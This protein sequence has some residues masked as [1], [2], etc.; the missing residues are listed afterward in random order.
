M[1]S[2]ASIRSQL[3]AYEPATNVQIGIKSA[4]AMFVNAEPQLENDECIS[5]IREDLPPNVLY[6]PDAL[7]GPATLH[8][9]LRHYLQLK[10]AVYT[11]H[12]ENNRIIFGL[13]SM[14]YN[15]ESDC[16]VALNYLR[17][18]RTSSN[19]SSI[20]Q[21]SLEDGV[22]NALSI[23][24][25][26]AGRIAHNMATRFKLA[27]DKFSG[28]LDENLTEYLN[29]YMDASNDYGLTLQQ[30]F[31]YLHHLFDGEAKRFFR[32]NVMESCN[33]FSEACSL[34]QQEFNSLTRQS[35]VRK[36][37][38]KL[39]IGEV[40]NRKKC[41]VAEALEELREL[42]TKLAPQ[43][44]KTHRSDEAKVEYLYQAVV[45]ASWAKASLSAS[46][47]SNPP[48]TFQKLY[49]SLD[50]AWLQEQEEIEA[51]QRDKGGRNNIESISQGTLPGIFYQGQGIY[52]KPRQV[53]SKSSAPG[54]RYSHSPGSEAAIGKNGMD[55]YGRARLCNNCKSPDHF[56][57]ACDK[58]KNLVNNVAKMIQNKKPAEIR[59]ILYEVCMQ[60]ENA[61]WNDDDDPMNIFFSE[62]REMNDNQEIF[63][64]TDEIHYKSGNDS[65][66]PKPE[67]F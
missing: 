21:S 45:G 3:A 41:S 11:Q 43:G 65:E 60:A 6:S 19:Q 4:L 50:A 2:L 8:R 7:Q 59:Q 53:G 23:G 22:Q 25:K 58:P 26:S 44:P 29:N 56:I 18:Q 13:I 14:I 48:W 35:R 67:D 10:N 57:R 24:E 66:I 42:I 33:S 36:H 52:G 16:E 32:S 37:L 28:K 1:T 61:V 40:M 64:A 38:Q 27:D 63:E 54:M 15:N 5:G 51:R 31:N 62:E 20:F 17:S 49:S 39:R 55:H 47:S 34:M 9:L 30:K 46:Q 12:P